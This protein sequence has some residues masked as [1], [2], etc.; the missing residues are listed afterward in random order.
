M[1]QT[2]TKEDLISFEDDIKKVFELGAI[3]APVHFSGGNEDELISIFENVK[4]HDWVFSTH[5]SHYH[6]LLK[7]I[8]R[9]WLKVEI[10]HGRS[11]CI[12]NKEH[13]FFSSAIVAGAL[14]IALGMA[15]S[16]QME[17]SHKHVWVFVGD[18]AAETGTFHEVIKYATRNDLPITFIIEDNSYSVNT[19]TQQ[20]WGE[21]CSDS[22]L[23]RYYYRREFPHQGTGRWVEF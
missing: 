12:M 13:S 8:D 10:L 17:D 16:I 5:R 3:R 19:P 2:I 9:E 18:M 7:G 15:L 14:P 22:R 20:C 6:A 1:I 4:E 11:I 21:N 23:M